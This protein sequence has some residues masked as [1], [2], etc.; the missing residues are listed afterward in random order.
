[1]KLLSFLLVLSVTLTFCLITA[2]TIFGQAEKLGAVAYTPVKGWK[3]TVK[4]NLVTFSEIDAAAGTFCTITLYGSS[5]GTGRAESDFV[6]EWNNL[7]VKPFGA[8]A[9]PKTET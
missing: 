2:E 4:E 8:K 3:K 9:G 6:R 5:A 1:M 7:V